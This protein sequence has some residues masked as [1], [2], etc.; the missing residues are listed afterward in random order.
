MGDFQEAGKNPFIKRDR[1]NPVRLYFEQ[2][3]QFEDILNDLNK[4][5]AAIMFFMSYSSFFL[6][7][8]L[9]YQ[10]Q[11]RSYMQYFFFIWRRRHFDTGLP[12]WVG[13]NKILKVWQFKTSCWCFFCCFCTIYKNILFIW[14]T[15]YILQTLVLK[16]S[17]SMQLFLVLDSRKCKHKKIIFNRNK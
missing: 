8:G 14:K 2:C 4:S 1:L 6:I 15:F 9:N 12:S 10:K 5:L 3:H 17:I 16:T 11:W 13:K 7:K